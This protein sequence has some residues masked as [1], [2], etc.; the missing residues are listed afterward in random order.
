MVAA[1]RA[2]AGGASLPGKVLYRVGRAVVA[3]LL[4]T[5]ARVEIQG[6][7]SVPRQGPLLVIANHVS[8]F[9]PMLLAIAVPRPLAFLAKEE[10]FHPAPWGWALRA[11][12][13]IPVRRGHVDRQA[14]AAAE[15]VLRQG[16]ALAIFPE[17]RRSGDAR[18]QAGEPGAGLLALRSAAPVLP[19]ALLGTERL[20]RPGVWMR[21][22]RLV[23]RC[24]AVW[25]PR[26]AA[27]AGSAAYR[28]VTDEM[29]TRLAALMPAARRGYYADG[30]PA[31]ASAGATGH[32]Q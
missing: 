22:P 5:F 32:E 11:A 31:R 30:R 20:G 4:R 2:A 27:R 24:G 26:G 28:C 29:M 12:G 19:V 18:L 14:L 6:A 9:D 1:P 15:D 17:G 10:L 8:Y 23:A 16:G 3:V 21:R 7:A 13:I 25:Q